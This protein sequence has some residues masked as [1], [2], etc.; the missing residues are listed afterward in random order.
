MA[1]LERE[2]ARLKAAAAGAAPTGVRTTLALSGD[3]SPT[4]SNHSV[5]S[6]MAGPTVDQLRAKLANTKFQLKTAMSPTREFLLKLKGEQEEELQ[7]AR[8][9]EERLAEAREWHKEKSRK[10]CGN[11]RHT[12]EAQEALRVSLE[13]ET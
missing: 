13:R 5:S 3:L 1:N 7:G 10:V 12:A 9:I 6:P 8:P 4:L 11:Q 2:N